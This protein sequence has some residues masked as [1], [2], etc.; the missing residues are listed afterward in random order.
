MLA[1]ADDERSVRVAAALAIVRIDPQHDA[2]A[3]V[4]GQAMRS[5][6][7]GVIV[8]VG[9]LEGAAQWALPILISLLESDPRPGIR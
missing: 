4:L 3:G 8:Q 9:N 1:L 6:D 7:G 5:G 2:P